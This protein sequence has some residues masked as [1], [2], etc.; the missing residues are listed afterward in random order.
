MSESINNNIS[1]KPLSA[2]DLP[3]THKWLTSSHVKE[4]YGHGKQT[5]ADIEKKYIP[6]INGETPTSCFIIFY[7]NAPIGQIQMYKINDYPDY[8]KIIQ[9]DQS[10]AGIDL[11]I[12]E[13]DFQH[14]GLGSVIIQKFLKDF[15]FKK[16]NVESCII[17]PN[18]NNIAAIKAYEKAGFKYLKTIINPDGE[19]EYLMEKEK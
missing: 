6:R 7:D 17:G 11:F 19:D 2:V 5:I 18:P 3:L 16:L 15:V 8:K 10:A 4:G 1:F 14:K 13:K 9:I 12:G